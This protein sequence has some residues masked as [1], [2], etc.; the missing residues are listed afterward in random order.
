MS[1]TREIVEQWTDKAQ[2][3]LRQAQELC[4]S[5]EKSLAAVNRQL[6][7]NL[8]KKLTENDNKLHDLRNLQDLITNYI[9]FIRVKIS[10][11]TIK[12]YDHKYQ[13]LQP[14]LAELNDVMDQLA[15][16]KVPSILIDSNY[17]IKEEA[18][19]KDLT[20]T[21]EID[22]LL[23]NIDIY[24][25]NMLKMHK[26][27]ND[28]FT[29]TIVI[30]FNNVIT[31]KFNRITKL[32]N[33]LIIENS[34]NSG[35][36][37]QVLKENNS[38]E[39]E[40]VSILEMLT[41]HYDQC[42]LGLNSFNNSTSVDLEVLQNDSLEVPEVL[43]DLKSVCDVIVNNEIRS[44]RIISSIFNKSDELGEYIDDLNKVHGKFKSTNLFQLI[45]FL[46][47]Y[48]DFVK[49]SPIESTE[50]PLDNYFH[51]IT[52]LTYHYRQF[53]SIFKTKYLVEL[54]HQQF[55]FP[56]KFMAKLNKFL[57]EEL[58]EFQQEEKERR[59]HWLK[60]YGDFIPKQFIL[61]GDNQPS[62]VQVITEGVDDNVQQEKQLL[63]VI[64]NF[65]DKPN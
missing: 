6:S 46:S 41:N 38:L 15:G 34:Q 30:P 62:V 2:F 35:L 9:N 23:A 8:P 44:K 33:E 39:G 45:V 64:R 10:E 52:Q 1:I 50:H 51:V 36:L 18:S 63:D 28:S 19:L 3:T 26:F 21:D 57:N 47:K 59:D 55:T 5:T 25:S 31:K 58:Y 60:K 20:S 7:E 29:E 24:H 53:L 56:R 27:M 12:V 32:H 48:D 37:S 54:H 49:S 4:S 11:D 65:M 43:K 61:P 13:R 42:V 16:T 14:C 17:N 22:V 40:L